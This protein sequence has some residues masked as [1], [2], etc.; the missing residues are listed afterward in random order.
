[1]MKSTVRSPFAVLLAAVFIAAC[2]T[3]HH[4]LP[5]FDARRI[6]PG[7]YDK[8]VEHLVFILD[9]SSSM[10]DPYQGYEKM[11]I[12]RGVIDNVNNTMPE[13]DMAVTLRSFGHADSVSSASSAIMLPTQGY[14]RNALASAVA[15]VQEAGGTSSM[16]RSLYDAAKDLKAVDVPIAMVIVSDG[17]DMAAGT[18]AATVATTSAEVT[19]AG[20]WLYKDIQFENNKA[21]L[22]A[23]SLPTLNEISAALKAQP[24]LKIEIYGHTDGSGAR[25]YNLDLS[26]RRA[27]SVKAFLETSGIDAS[28]MRSMGFGPDRPIDSNTTKA[29]RA[30]NRRVEIKPIR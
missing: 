25:A 5:N 1:M 24:G 7:Q 28:R 29:G 26:R 20:T 12:A 9:A 22:R 16:A 2:A 6:D 13:L 14:S 17:R 23:S 10:A 11:D 30:K 19:A 27:E 4:Q 8:K 15:R 18:L 21:E 3:P